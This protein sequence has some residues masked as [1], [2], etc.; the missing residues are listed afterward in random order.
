MWIGKQG[1]GLEVHLTQEQ[2]KLWNQPSS[3]SPHVTFAIARGY[4]TTDRGH[5]VTSLKKASEAILIG[6]SQVNGLWRI[7]ADGYCWSVSRDCESRVR[8]G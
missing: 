7:G 6:S 8:D 2:L 5:M 4:Q 3:V 1:I